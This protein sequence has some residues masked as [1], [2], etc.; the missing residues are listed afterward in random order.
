MRLLRRP[1][2]IAHLSND[3]AHS[4]LNISD[5]RLADDGFPPTPFHRPSGCARCALAA[6]HMDLVRFGA[7]VVGRFA[8]TLP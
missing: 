7:R 6:T 1:L 2:Q 5:R 4:A 3:L 8:L